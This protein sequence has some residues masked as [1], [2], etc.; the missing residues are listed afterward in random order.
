ML[1][2]IHK[3]QDIW[4]F[5]IYLFYYLCLQL[6]QNGLVWVFWPKIISFL[7]FENFSFSGY[8]LY[9]YPKTAFSSPLSNITSHQPRKLFQ[10]CRNFLSHIVPNFQNYKHH[11][12]L[13]SSSQFTILICQADYL[14]PIVGVI[15]P[16]LLWAL[17]KN[18][19]PRVF[20]GLYIDLLTFL[21]PR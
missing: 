1:S 20:W 10:F 8:F 7:G 18:M 6:G 4:L 12:K 2:K 11:Y 3:S 14:L 17:S 16:G 9:R 21:N 13:I 5:P 19:C 15:V